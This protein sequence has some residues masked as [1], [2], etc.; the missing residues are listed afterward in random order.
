M[1]YIRNVL[2][3][4]RKA[5]ETFA[6]I[7]PGDVI[8][9][10]ISGGKDS[11]CLLKAMSL[12]GRFAKK[13]FRIVPIT[14]DL[15]FPGFNAEKISEYCASLGMKLRVE[16]SREVFPILQS[17]TKE[18]GHIPCSICSRMKKA[19]INA[20]A[21]KYHC[22]KVA[23]AHHKD[24][25][26]ETLFMN[27][28]HGG[29]VATFEPYMRLDRAKIT[30]IRPLIFASEAD[31]TGMAKEECLPVMGKTCPADG[32]T[33]REWIKDKLKALYQ[34]R[35]GSEANLAS[36]LYDYKNA[37]LYFEHIETVNPL[38]AAFSFRPLLSAAQAIDYAEFAAKS[39]RKPLMKAD[40]TFLVY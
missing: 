12:Y 4:L 35:D 6:L 33:E 39:K 25:A 16:D 8:A 10:G 26:V 5:D 13:D 24:D 1:K 11:L 27:M 36:M 7:D 21:K 15:G 14:L 19:A 40:E 38:D 29:R 31:L 9:L 20:A 22:N 2:A 23:F 32:F 18:G 34:E 30:F 37:K 28:I 17:H 3:A